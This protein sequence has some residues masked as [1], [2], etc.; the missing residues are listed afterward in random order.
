MELNERKR[1][2]VDFYKGKEKITDNVQESANKILDAIDLDSML[3][4]PSE[5]LK[6]LGTEWLKTQQKN[7]NKAYKVGRKH[8]KEIVKEYNGENN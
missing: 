5:Y 3:T 8:G 4:N 2:I 6:L 1:F 7:F